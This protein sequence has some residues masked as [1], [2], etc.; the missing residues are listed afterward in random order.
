MIV[1]RLHADLCLCGKDGDRSSSISSDGDMYAGQGRAAQIYSDV[2][3]MQTK[4]DRGL[5]F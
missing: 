1:Y 4:T 2:I 5:F 3:M